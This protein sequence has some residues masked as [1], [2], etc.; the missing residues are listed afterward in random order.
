MKH[1]EKDDSN[2]KTKFIKGFILY[3]KHRR[4]VDSALNN[5]ETIN[6]T[7]IDRLPRP[8]QNTWYLH[9]NGL[10]QFAVQTYKKRRGGG[11]TASTRP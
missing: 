4:D 5:P 2:V 9:T 10:L 1:V 8:S 6:S 7:R 3:F 11:E